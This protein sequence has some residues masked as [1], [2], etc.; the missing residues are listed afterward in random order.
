MPLFADR[1][2]RIDTENAFKIGPYIKSIEDAG[3]R[4]IKC[5]L[6]EPDFAVPEHIR[7]EVKRQLDAD[8][9]HYNDPQGIPALRTALAE[10]LKR[11]RGVEVTPE[12][13]VCFPGAKPPIGLC[14]QTYTNRGDEIIYPSP[15]FPIYESFIDY[16]GARPVPLHLDEEKGFSF[17][18][19]ELEPLISERTRLIY[20]NF[21]SNPTGGVA[22]REQLEGIARV[23]REKAPADARV[24]SDEVYEDILFDGVEHNS[25]ASLPGMA[26]RTIIVSG[27]SKSYCWTGGRVGWAAFPTVEEAQVFKNLNIN[28]FS[29][30]PAYNQEGAREAIESPLSKPILGEM[31]AAFQKRRDVVVNG[32]NRIEGI[33]CQLPRGAFYVFPN[34]GGVCERI[35][36]ISACERLLDEQR[37]MTSPATLFQMFLLFR[38]QVATMDRKSFGRIGTEGKHFLRLSIATGLDDLE[39]ALRRIETAADDTA[40]FEEFVA[41]GQCLY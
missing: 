2:R 21:P 4:V 30:L 13:V 41:A 39:E 5:N 3:N 38:Y 1:V 28:Y 32:L 16:V 34:I 35:G 15:G 25:I 36:A 22:T 31:S 26:Q 18:G 27:V 40:G 17:T 7:A 9:T 33:T 8:N 19:E 24:Y 11:S 23:I 37:R 20:V 10:H 14:Q 29:C 6:G 12:R